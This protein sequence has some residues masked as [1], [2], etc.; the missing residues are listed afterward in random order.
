MRGLLRR[1]KCESYEVLV[2]ASSII[3]PG[4]A[5]SGMMREYIYRHNNPA[6]FE[7]FHPVFKEHLED[8]Y[9][10]M[11]YQ[12]DVIKIAHHFGGI[13]LDQA[14][15]LRRG[16]S[17]KTRSRKELE[18]V[19]DQFFENCKR[20]GHLDELTAEVYRQIESFAGYSFCKS[21]SASYAVESYQSLYL[22][23]YFP[24]EFMVAVIN[25]FGGF[26]RTEV[27]VHEARMAGGTLHV[28][29]VNKSEYLTT[30]DGKDI[31]LGFIHVQGLEKG[32][33]E[34]LIN[35]RQ[36]NGK[37]KSLEDFLNRN[38]MGVET[39]L[40]LIHVGALHFT[41]K[42]KA[43]LNIRARLL[44]NKAVPR[45]P[46]QVLFDIGVKNYKMPELKGSVEED[47]FDETEL[48]GFPVSLLPFDVLKTKYRGGVMVAD[49]LKHENKV[50]KMLAYLISRKNV[51][52]NKGNMNFG[53]WVDFNGDYFDTTHFPDI[54]KAYPFRGTGC[55]LLLGKVTIDFHFPTVEIM[56]M[57]KLPTIPDP[58]YSDDDIEDNR[59]MSKIKEDF[60]NTRRS[61]YPSRQEVNK[62]YN[63]DPDF[64]G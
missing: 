39:A 24:L 14:D 57:S 11:V 18:A 51:P 64:K 6:D 20:I 9:G 32:V 58:R 34:S 47:A 10:I 2:A 17:G 5:K 55:Y 53:T 3:R 49:L 8:T 26:Y 56:K 30:L 27:Y 7:Y 45:Y 54:L 62:L 61:P 44:L 28:P 35:E 19:R 23:A 25:N 33:A 41:G 31:H 37:Y 42:S 48:L 63:R 36:R 59:I 21:H 16:M 15:I 1:L 38:S 4:V 43:A 60:S 13:G 22:K 50:V 40:L 52:T 46:G 12:E 29:C